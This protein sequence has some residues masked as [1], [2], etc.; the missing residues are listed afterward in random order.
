MRKMSRTIAPIIGEPKRQLR[1]SFPD[2]GSRDKE[3]RFASR[4]G[5]V[6]R[7]DLRKVPW[8]EAATLFDHLVSAD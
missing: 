1:R 8:A 7:K 3:A 5:V 2:I 6:D 4:T